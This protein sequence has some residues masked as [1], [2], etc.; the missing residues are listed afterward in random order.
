MHPETLT[1]HT[2]GSKV[3][4]ALDLHGGRE[5]EIGYANIVVTAVQEDVGLRGR[6]AQEERKCLKNTN[7]N[8][9]LPNRQKF[10]SQTIKDADVVHFSSGNT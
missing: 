6:G 4:I 8:F 9:K 5:L 7:Y 1:V 3:T 2:L 10:N